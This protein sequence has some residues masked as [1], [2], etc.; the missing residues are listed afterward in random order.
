MGDMREKLAD[1]IF[2][3]HEGKTYGEVADNQAK[4]ILEK[5]HILP[6]DKIRVLKKIYYR[7]KKDCTHCNLQ[8]PIED[9]KTYRTNCKISKILI[10]KE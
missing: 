9:C 10:V 8:L 4:A 2:T 5:Y 6:K 3:A 1:L 7:H